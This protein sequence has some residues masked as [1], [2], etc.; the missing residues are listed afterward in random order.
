MTVESKNDIQV[1]F[2]SNKWITIQLFNKIHNCSTP[3]DLL[4]VI[5]KNQL[6]DLRPN[7]WISL[8]IMLTIPVTV[9]SGE[10]SFSKQLKL[11]KVN[12]I[13]R[14]IDII[15]NTLGIENAIAQNLDFSR[16]QWKYSRTK[17]RKKSEFSLGFVFH[18]RVLCWNSHSSTTVS[19]R[20]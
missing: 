20:M 3:L 19:Y 18:L 4:N 11:I 14:K 7:E 10:R 5:K 12:H 8:K 1:V 9:A 2:L 17:N 16:N 15:G 6:E 13:T